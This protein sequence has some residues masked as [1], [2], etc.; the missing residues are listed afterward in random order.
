[1]S[2]K[3]TSTN[4][5][6]GKK[7][8]MTN[9]EKAKCLAWVQERVM[10][11]EIARRLQVSKSSV[12]RL[13]A[14]S[15]QLTKDAIP[16]RKPG[17]GGQWKVSNAAIKTI[18]DAIK[19]NPRLTSKELKIQHPKHLNNLSTRTIR[20]VLLEEL[21]LKSH[22]A[23]KKPYL[24]KLMKKKRL[25]F[26]KK[27]LKW[28]AKQW[29][30]CLFTDESLFLTLRNTG[31]RVRRKR[32]EGRY[33]EKYTK[34]TIKH[35]A[36]IMI[37]TSFSGK[38]GPGDIFFLRPNTKMTSSLYIKVLETHLTSTMRKHQV[39]VFFQDRA[40]PHT[41][42]NTQKYMRKNGM[43]TVFLPSSSPDLNPIENSFSF[44]KSALDKENTS[45]IPMLKKC[46]MRHWKRLGRD[47]F[48]K[49]SNSMP[50]R[51]NEIVKC[52]G[53]MTKY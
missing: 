30:K 16:S 18:H 35:P 34:K 52:K 41:A 31:L 7:K 42:G 24:S 22:V 10:Q 1:M 26:A 53:A 44:L 33:D 2:K 50:R 11:E 21:E 36:G 17:S 23:A 20:R 27:Y 38:G 13:V 47:Y 48:L 5:K 15:K 51:L 19:K 14:K 32:G 37:W 45:S 25:A 40:T 6:R 46:I 49:L 8:H 28:T 9:V 29:E 3:N 43:K 12:K 4:K 39:N